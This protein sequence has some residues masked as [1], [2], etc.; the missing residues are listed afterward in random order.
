MDAGGSEVEADEPRAGDS[1]AG[2]FGAGELPLAR[3]LLGE[4]GEIFAGTGRVEIR[5]D[6]I[7]CRVQLD[8]HDD[9]EGAVDGGERFLRRFRQDFVQ[10][11]AAPDN[12]AGCFCAG[13][14]RWSRVQNGRRWGERRGFDGP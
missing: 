6:Y 8:F 14:G 1:V 5:I 12:R 13:S 3:G 4:A 2:G 9:V 11:F 7:S 10:D